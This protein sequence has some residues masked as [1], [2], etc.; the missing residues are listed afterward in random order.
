MTGRST[1][2][3]FNDHLQLRAA[4]DLET[5]LRRNY[6]E[7]V[8]VL[9]SSGVLHGLDGMRK[10]AGRLDEQLPDAEFSYVTRE[11]YGEYAFLEWQA[12]SDLATV[13]DGADSF[14][15]RDGLIRMQTIHYTL[16]PS[17]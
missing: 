13:E 6:A 8:V 5:D 9:C 1:A 10:S 17:S 2:D 15:I 7:D 3:V 4:G 16:K 11:V 14:V 12:T